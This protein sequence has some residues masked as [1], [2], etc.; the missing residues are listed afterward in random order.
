MQ[1]QSE[2]A[3]ENTQVFKALFEEYKDNPVFFAE[4]AL[5]HMTWSK[6]REILQ[7]VR[8]NKRT[9]VRACHGSSKTYTAAEAAVWFLNCF[10]KSKVITT[11][12]TYS[13]MAHLLWAEINQIYRNSRIRL[14]GECL[15][16]RIK[17]SEPNHFAIGFS[18]DQPAKAEGWHAPE[19]L[20]IFDEAKG[21]PQWLW[22]SVRGLMTGGFIRWLVISTTDGVEVGEQYYKIFES[23]NNGWNKIHIKAEDSPYITGE[24]F[25]YI[26]IP[27]EEH[28]ERFRR[29]EAS[30]K[31]VNIQIADQNYMRECEKEWGTDSALYLTKV[32]GQIVDVGADTIIKL[33]QTEKMFANWNDSK[34]NDEGQKEI[35]VDV[36]RG[37]SDDTLFFQRKG[38]KYLNHKKISAKQMPPTEK[39]EFLADELEIFAAHD[40]E[41]RI[42][43]DDTGVGG[44]L[45]DIMQRRG[46]KI[47]P[48]NF[49]AEANEPDKYPNT[50][51]E[52]WFE[53]GKIIHEI[54]CPEITRLQKELVNRKYKSLDKKGRRVIESKDDYK[55]R[56]F[57]SPDYADAFLLCFY[58]RKVKKGGA[59]IPDIGVD[60]IWQ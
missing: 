2:I 40:K 46:Y 52:M 11:A 27:N 10:R 14:E 3:Q 34:F 28:P 12:P 26:D 50:I 58:N 9:A 44:G 41:N 56:G 43:I 22:D 7:S 8:N 20:F 48:I 1:T 54:A 17:T 60:D 45:T 36:A 53:V 16:N 55:S 6:Q 29:A 37:G 5:G 21:V 4:H 47:I 42:K 35:G 25:R 23:D 38:M 32:N 49:A 18:T 15:T 30:P 24:K 19:I 39:L 51:S 57:P 31:D 59:G 13:Q 33:S